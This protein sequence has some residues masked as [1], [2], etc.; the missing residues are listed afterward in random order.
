L[1]EEEEEEEEELVCVSEGLA[2][3]EVSSFLQH[4]VVLDFDS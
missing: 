2:K 4:S 3:F 1:Y